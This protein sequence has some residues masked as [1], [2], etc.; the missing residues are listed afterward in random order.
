MDKSKDKLRVFLAAQ[1]TALFGNILDYCDVAVGDKERMRSLR[2]RILKMGNDTIRK[3][4]KEVDDRYSV[5]YNAP[6]EEVIVVRSTH[7]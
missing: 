4:G 2:S 7:K 6:T 3:V 1:I 5:V